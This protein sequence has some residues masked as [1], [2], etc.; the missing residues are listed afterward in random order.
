VSTYAYKHLNNAK[1]FRVQ[2][3]AEYS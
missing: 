1:K 3:L 2:H